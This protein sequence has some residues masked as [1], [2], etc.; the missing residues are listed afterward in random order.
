MSSSPSKRLGRVGTFSL[1]IARIPDLATM[2]DADAVVWPAPARRIDT[3]VGWGRKPNTRTARAFAARRGLPFL[4]LEDG[5]LRSV[6]LGVEGDPPLSVV[7]DEE[8]IYYDAG[9]PSTLE[10]LVRE[11]RLDDD[12]A[13]RAA[14]AIDAMLGAKLSKYNDAPVL[15]LPRT[16]RQRVLVVDQTAN[17]MSLELG[18][19]SGFDTMLRAAI[20]E[21][22]E[23]EII[24]KTHPDVAVGRKRGHYSRRDAGG[25]VVLRTERENPIS[26]LEQVDRVYVMTSLLGFEALLAEKPVV[27]FGAPFY[28][29]WGLTDDR[30]DVPLERRGSASLEQ[31]FWSAYARYTRYRDPETGERC[32]VERVIEHLRLQREVGGVSARTIVA[33]GFSAWKRAFLPSFLT[34]PGVDVKLVDDAPAAAMHTNAA[35]ALV[36]WGTGRDDVDRLARAQRLPVWR[37]EDGFL[38]S[39]GLGSDLY[40]P[41]SLVVDT[42]GLYYD[43]ATVSDLEH[44][45]E[46]AEFGPALLDRARALRQSIIEARVSKYN[47][48]RV[49]RAIRATGRDVVLVVGQVEDDA[50]IERGCIDVSRNEDLLR[51]AR[52]ARPHAHVV[53]KPHPDVVSGNRRDSLPL[54]VASRMCDQVV[55]DASL[56]DCLA[57]ADE[58]H[59]LT[60]LVGFEALL[61]RLPVVCYGQPFYAGWG[62]TLDRH[63]HPRRTRR[64][65]L[66]EL[67]AGALI[68]YP[69][70]VSP[71]SGRYTTPEH[72]VTHLAMS[73]DEPASRLGGTW[74]GR[75]ARKLT[76]L[77]KELFRAP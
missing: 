45:L 52:I 43:P 17:D 44:I 40:A 30:G 31:L 7:V 29:G 10:R 1:G 6:G 9:R 13:A 18:R 63:P 34:G 41:A 5:F 46:T 22:P 66:D 58:V 27:C 71:R 25:R 76:N 53:Y 38:R 70:Y 56:P 73:K 60:S 21:N 59:T 55:V 26:L 74:T 48:G 42:R 51:L 33:V 64:L 32:E 49:G 57:A 35:S 65:S 14:A 50:S 36:V 16:S 4:A 19:A 20:D 15:A 75:Q 24:L 8:G 47:I 28:A 67:V 69:R 61:R 54:A 12:E 23:A 62:L 2:L 68:L 11:T 72:I 39:V 37:M 3:V 77:G